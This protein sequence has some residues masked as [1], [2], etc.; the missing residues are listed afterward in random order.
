M[1]SLKLD[2]EVYSPLSYGDMLYANLVESEGIRLLG[3]KF[4]PIRSL[5]HANDYYNFLKSIDIGI[6][7]SKR[8]A[9]AGNIFHLLGYGKSV[10]I[11]KQSTV[12]SQCIRLGFYLK[13]TSFINEGV[14]EEKHLQKNVEIAKDILSKAGLIKSWKSLLGQLDCEEAIYQNSI[15]KAIGIAP[16][17][18]LFRDGY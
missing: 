4:H 11:N 12:Y 9:G 16:W 1:I 6:F 10:Y 18:K 17:A 8:Q 2:Y 7:D 5:M 14:F 15:H 3:K 13:D